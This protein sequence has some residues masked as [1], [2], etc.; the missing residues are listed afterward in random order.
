MTEI[1]FPS[2][3]IVR[4]SCLAD[5]DVNAEWRTFGL[6]LDPRWR[7]GWPADVVNWP[8]F[9]VPDQ[10]TLVADSITRAYRAAESGERIEVGCL[11][12]LGRTGTVLAC[13]AI[14]AGIP[15]ERAVAWVR[16]NYDARAVETAEQ[17]EWVAWFAVYAERYE[18]SNR[19]ET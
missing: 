13:M 16:E 11:G 5:R 19:Q 12:G 6:Y 9:G 15:A 10:P 1:Q 4:A 7:P 2:G 17:E 14:L 8:D 18:I 3:V